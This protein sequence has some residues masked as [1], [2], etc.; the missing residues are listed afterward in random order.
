M[1]SRMRLIRI[2]G[3]V[4]GSAWFLV[5][6]CTG[7]TFI[8]APVVIPEFNTREVEKGEQLH[9]WFSVV[10]EPGDNE[11]PF[12]PFQ[13]IRKDNLKPLLPHS[14]NA[15]AAIQ[16]T[17]DAKPISFLMPNPTGRIEEEYHFIISYR[18]VEDFGDEQIIELEE[19]L[20]KAAI[21]RWSVYKARSISISPLSSR[22]LNFRECM[23][24]GFPIAV[25][26]SLVL[27]L[28]G[29]LLLFIAR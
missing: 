5:A 4:L 8:V 7:G 28:I 9:S 18:V 1:N 23:L 12:H 6:S 29:R 16:L 14:D 25:I 26:G 21:M 20:K 15:N 2:I 13:V 22:V 11:H 24:I 10:A 27:F 3:M 19:N 17:Y